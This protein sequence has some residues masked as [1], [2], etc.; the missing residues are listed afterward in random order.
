MGVKKFRCPYKGVRWIDSKPR[1]GFVILRN[2][3][4]ED[5]LEDEECLEE[6]KDDIATLAGRY[7]TLIKLEV[8]L[9]DST[10]KLEYAGGDTVAATAARELHGMVIGGQTVMATSVPTSG[11][12]PA[13][14]A[15]APTPTNLAP[16][17]E[18]KIK[19]TD[20][21]LYSGDKLIPERFA[22]MK[23][24]PKVAN[25]GT[26]RKYASLVDDE[27]VKPLLME[28]LSEL[29]RL[30]KRAVEEKECQGKATIS[31]GAER[32]GSRNSGSQSENGGH[33]EQLG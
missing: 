32:G 29:M 12:L 22:E 9:E 21:V 17:E 19:A 10:V 1:S 3:L 4:T 7:G 20:Q 6:S 8:N 2:V 31:H 18:D 30:Q 25:V 15:I 33:G 23:R 5:D 26:P 16:Q 13:T 27:E 24:A 28:M 14:G 11:A